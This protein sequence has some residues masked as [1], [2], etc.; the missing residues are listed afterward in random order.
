[1]PLAG[2][3]GLP[4]TLAFGPVATYNVLSSLALATAASS[5]FFVARRWV[6]WTP[7]AFLAGLLFGFGPFMVGQAQGHL[8]LTL[9]FPLPLLLLVFDEVL[10]R[11]RWAWWRAG[12][13]LGGLVVLELGLSLELL[14]DALVLA[15][16]G[17][18]ALVIVGRDAVAGKVGYALR[19]IGLGA[20]LAAPFLGWYL[21]TFVA[22]AWHKT[23]AI[24]PVAALGDLSVTLAGL[25]AP[26]QNQVVNLGVGEW[27]SHLVHLFDAGKN[28]AANGSYVG[29]PLLALA[30]GGLVVLWRRA[31]MRCFAFLAAVSL[32]L[33]LGARLRIAGA[34]TPVP[35]PFALFAR[36]PF[37]DDTIAIRW[38][39]FT[40]LFVGLMGAMSLD[41]LR[42]QARLPAAPRR[43]RRRY[44]LSLVL[45]VLVV[46]SM[47]PP[48]P[49][50]RIGPIA[51]PAWFSSPA[52][53]GIEPG[54]AVLVYPDAAK[55][56]S[57]SMLDQA[58][59]KMRWRVVGGE[60][61]TSD[62][63]PPDVIAGLQACYSDPTLLLPAAS[64]VP[65]TPRRAC[66]LGRVDGPRHRRG[67]QPPLRRRLPRR[68]HR[69]ASD[70]RRRRRGLDSRQ[71]T[72][73]AG[74]SL[75]RNDLNSRPSTTGQLTMVQWG[76]L[77]LASAAAGRRRNRRAIRHPGGRQ[78]PAFRRLGRNP[79]RRV[80]RR[81]SCDH[82][83]RQRPRHS[84]Q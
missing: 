30:L 3:L 33:S 35:L 25:V 78:L 73:R 49:Q 66:G 46:V 54:S 29:I 37:L 64:L 81:R 22:G 59:D 77:A 39:V 31:P 36:L 69:P 56:S 62:A 9:A 4:V 1:M 41:G 68:A 84:H 32:L 82:P 19:A 42:E 24:H 18:L 72:R 58:V 26:S 76:L 70:A 8:F 14:T 79:L 60:T 2:L 13:A 23:G 20:L 71:L 27:S 67:A 21:W 80:Q 28:L 47:L 57:A 74:M 7:A 17:T 53:A 51:V 43:A 44:A 6:S 83:R 50:D 11:Q 5:A 52:A 40:M 48:W 34:R 16:A 45:A 38:S 55:R 15:A 75:F 61:G 63:A 10:V 12:A 65:G